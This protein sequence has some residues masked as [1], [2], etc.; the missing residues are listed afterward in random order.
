MSSQAVA[1]LDVQSVEPELKTQGFDCFL[2]RALYLA[3]LHVDVIVVR[4]K[5]KTAIQKGW[6]EAA[7]QNLDT[8]RHWAKQFPN[9]NTGAVAN[10]D[11]LWLLDG[12]DPTIPERYERDTGET[13]PTTFAVESRPGH[14]HYYFRPT[15]ASR[16]L[17]NQSQDKVAG[18]AF[19]VRAKNEYVVGPG[20][21]HPVTGKPYLIVCDDNLVPVPDSLIAWVKT[22]IEQPEQPQTATSAP[23]ST[24]KIPQG[25][26]NCHLTSVAGRLHR[27]GLSNEGL[28]DELLRRNKSDCDP[29]LSS[30]E[31]Q[32]IAKS[33]GRYEQPDQAPEEPEDDIEIAEEPLPEFPV[34]PGSIGQLSEALCADLPMSFKAMAAI[35]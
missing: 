26:R 8:V 34:V 25:G 20:S 9:H 7:T 29:P 23:A 19:S 4:P 22:Q 14:C 33:I 10:P 28:L 18:K 2:D 35:N 1:A 30:G 12:D 32:S 16:G 21:I 5:S 3:A 24:Q 15:D 31:V 17:G 11:T 27:A 6:P 13:F